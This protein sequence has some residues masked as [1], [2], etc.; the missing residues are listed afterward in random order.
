MCLGFGGLET[1]VDVLK[2]AELVVS[3]NTG[4]MHL[5]AIV[6][7]PT[8][9]LNGPTATHRWGPVGPRVAVV[10]PQGGGGG[11]LHFGFEFAG[12]PADTME[13]IRVPEVAEVA[14]SLVPSLFS[15]TEKVSSLF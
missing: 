11:F 2:S 5:A 13:R 15:Q 4:I 3:V 12:N 8:I 14:R 10:E 7:A 9:A 1:I 6:G